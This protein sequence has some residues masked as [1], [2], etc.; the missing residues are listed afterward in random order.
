M[1][2]SDRFFKS[3]NELL[4]IGNQ[5]LFGLEGKES[6]IP[7]AYQYFVLAA[8]KGNKNA[9]HILDKFYAPGKNELRD[10][11]KEGFNELRQLRLAVEAGDPRACFQ[12]GVEKLQDDV[13]DYMYQKGLAWVKYSAE[14]KFI[15]AMHVYACELLRSKRIQINLSLAIDY[16]R[17]A[18]TQGYMPS[19]NMLLELKEKELAINI[20]KELASRKNADAYLFLADLNYNEENFDEAISLFEKYASLGNVEAMFNVAL[21]YDTLG[22]ICYRNPYKAA[23]WYEKAA[24]AG[25]VHAMTNLA[26]LLTTGPEEVR[27][28][29]AAFNWYVKASEAGLTIVWNNV[30]ACY[31]RGIG[32]E[33]SFEKARDSYLH[34]TKTEK[35]REAFYNLFLLYSDGASTIKNQC[36]AYYWLRKAAKEGVAQ[37]CWHLGMH[38]KLGIIVVQGLNQAFYWFKKSAEKGCPEAIYQLGEFFMNGICVER[39]LKKAFECFDKVAE[40]LP[41]A[42]NRLGHCY[43][44]G[45]GCSKDLRQA[46][47]CYLSAAKSGLAEAQLDLGVCFQQGEGVPVNINKAVEWYKKAISQGHTG[48]MVNYAILL[49][50][51]IGIVKNNELAYKYLKKAAEAGDSEAQ[52]YLGSMYFQG[53]GINQDYEEAVKWFTLAAKNGKPDSMY[54]LSY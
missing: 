25:E 21:I 16:L 13:N 32:T 48:A 17:R 34:A 40:I 9:V 47:R 33:Q 8:K 14:M 26:T 42:M 35:R 41:I 38:Y 50:S 22:G 36:E 19:L 10:K 49:D 11:I 4:E 6:N 15:P 12:Y 23:M 51:G 44:N 39:D 3:S 2:L 53:R 54:N 43:S 5:F 27:D 37:A 52:F 46:F 29:K 45:L 1:N 20:A 31:H 18:A 24:E 7:L 28:E 30:G